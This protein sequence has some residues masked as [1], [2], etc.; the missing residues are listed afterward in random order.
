MENLSLNWSLTTV[1]KNK[2]NTA[3]Q[4]Q[5]QQFMGA[6]VFDLNRHLP[7]TSTHFL[8]GR[9]IREKSAM[10]DAEDVGQGRWEVTCLQGL[11]PKFVQGKLLGDF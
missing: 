10:L 9:G 4:N 3:F 2:R 8:I 5:V 6:L 7:E 11:E 1:R